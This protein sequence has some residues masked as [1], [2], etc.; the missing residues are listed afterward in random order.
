MGKKVLSLFMAFMM[1]FS[2]LPTFLTAT[3]SAE[4]ETAEYAATAENGVKNINDGV[5]VV[6]GYDSEN[7]SYSYIYYGTRNGDGIKWRVLDN[8]TLDGNEGLFLLMENPIKNVEFIS[9]CTLG[10]LDSSRNNCWSCL[11][12]MRHNWWENSTARV[13]CRAFTE[14][15]SPDT[16][17]GFTTNQRS[18]GNTLYNNN[19][20]SYDQNYSAFS[21]ME[22]EKILATTKADKNFKGDHLYYGRDLNGEKVFFL[23]ADEASDAKYGFDTDANR[24]SNTTWMTRSAAWED[25]VYSSDL[26]SQYGDGKGVNDAGIG[27]IYGDGY[28]SAVPIYSAILD[29]VLGG[30][31]KETYSFNPI[32]TWSARPAMNISY[33]SIVFASAPDAAC[34]KTF[35]LTNSYSGNE[36]KLTL[37]TG[38]SFNA[39][40]STN[41]LS[42]DGIAVTHTALNGIGNTDYNT[43]TA[44]LKNTAGETVAYGALN[45]ADASAGKSTLPLPSGLADGT[46]TLTLRAEQWNGKNMTNYAS[47]AYDAGTIYVGRNNSHNGQSFKPIVN[48]FDFAAMTADD[49]GFL[50]DNI[51]VNPN[52]IYSGHLCLNGYTVNGDMQVRNFALYDDDG[53]SGLLD[54]SLTLTDGTLTLYGGTVNTG[55]NLNKG[56]LA[57][58]GGVVG[59]NNNGCSVVAESDTTV[60]FPGNTTFNG[61]TAGVYLKNGAYVSA[62]GIVHPA[63]PYIVGLESGT[64]SFC[65]DWN[66]N[67]D[68]TQYFS[69]ANGHSVERQGTTLSLIESS[70]LVPE[71]PVCGVRCNHKDS[72]PIISDW[73]VFNASETSLAD[74][75]YIL[76]SNITLEH[77]I[78]ITGNVNVC[79]NG[80][81]VTLKDKD[82]SFVVADGGTLSI[83]DCSANQT[84]RINGENASGRSQSDSGAV[85]VNKK[86]TF[87]LYTG[88]INDLSCAVAVKGTF[89]MY[90]GTVLNSDCG[91]YNTYT[92][93][94]NMY[95]GTVSACTYGVTAKNSVD[96]HNGSLIENCRYGLFGTSIK[97]NLS[98]T[99]RGC[100]VGISAGTLNDGAVVENCKIGADGYIIMQPGSTVRNCTQYGVYAA[101]LTM[102]G[103]TVT[104]CNVGVYLNPAKKSNGKNLMTVSGAP[105]INGNTAAN[106]AVYSKVDSKN[107][108]IEN[109]QAICIGN[110]GLTEEAVIPVRV[111][112][113]DGD[114][115]SYNADGTTSP[116]YT[117]SAVYPN[118][119]YSRYFQSDVPNF[120]IVHTFETNQLAVAYCNSTKDS[121]GNPVRT[122]IMCLLQYDANGG[123]GSIDYS[124]L[125]DS[126]FDKVWYIKA[127]NTTNGGGRLIPNP[128]T[129]PSGKTFAGW[130]TKADGSGVAYA[131][132]DIFRTCITKG[133]YFLTDPVTLY[134][135]WTDA[136][137]ITVTFDA[138]GGVCETGEK[139]VKYAQSYGELPTPTRDGYAFTGWYTD[140]SN[141]NKVSERTMVSSIFN[142]TLY[143]YWTMNTYTVSFNANGG[144]GE[145]A[146]VSVTSGGYTLPECT[147]TPPAGKKFKAW[148]VSG[149]EYAAGN[150]IN[151]SANTTVT[152]VWA[153]LEKT[154]VT[155]NETVQTNEYDGIVKDF[156]IKDANVTD[157]FT[158]KYQKDGNDVVLPTDA[159]DYD[160]VIERAEDGTYKEYKKTIT[161]GLKITKK[162]ITGATVGV[163]EEMTYNGTAQTPTASVTVDGLTVTGEWSKVTNVAD[164]TTFTANGNFKG[165]IA[166]QITGMEKAYSNFAIAPNAIR[167]TYNKNAQVLITAA[168]ADGGIV[169]YSIDDQKTWSEELP[170]AINAGKYVVCFKIFGDDNHK[171]SEVQFCNA[172]VAK[173]VVSVPTVDGKIYNGTQQTAKI[174]DTEYYTVTQNGGGINTGKYNVKLA[175]KDGANYYWDGNAENVSEI[176]LDFYITKANNEWTTAPSITDRTYG[177]SASAPVY[178]AK[179]GNVKVEYKKTNEDD[180]AYTT[181]VPKNAG[182]YNA[183]FTVDAT[184]DFG[185]LLEVKEFNIAKANVIFTEPTAQ[186]DLVYSGTAQAL[187]IGGSAEGGEILYSTAENGDYSADVIKGTN[188]GSYEVWYKVAG[189]SNHNDIAPQKIDVSIAKAVVS[190][191][192]IDGK[193]YNGTQQT[194]KIA[195]T[196]YYTV[197]QNGGGINTGKYNVKLALKDGA[198]YYWDG[199]AENVSEINLD[200]YITKANNEWTTAPSITDRTYGESAS[201]PVY[202]AKFGNVKVEYKKTNEDDSAYTTDV[203]KNAGNY[204]AK[205]TVDA[206]DDFGG[207]LEVK[208]FNIAKANVTFTEPT[209]QQDLV[210]NG[211]AQALTLGGSAE[212]GETLYATAE[213]GDY[214]ADVIKGTNAGSYEV[215]YKVAGDSNHNDIASQKIN[216]SIAKA[217]QSAPVQPTAVG[218]TIKGK[219]D[220]KIIGVS[221]DMEYKAD[222]ASEYTA[223]TE[224]EILNLTAGIY[225]VRY[226]ENDN[227]LAGG[228]K[229]I[230]IVAGEMI[231]V[232]FDSDGGSDIDSETCEYN[233]TIASPKDEP[234]KDGYEF[235]GWFA[236]VELTNEWNF[237]TTL[238]ENKTLYAKWVRGTVSDNEGD[239]D[240]VAA[241]GLND[242]AKSE[243]ADI[244]LVVRVQETADSSESQTAIKNIENAPKNFEF[245]D[246]TLKKSA[247]ETITEASSVIEIKLPYDFARKRNIKIYRYHNGNAVELTQLENRNT[248]KPFTDGTCFVDTQNGYIYIYSS[249]FSIYSVAYDKMSSS[250]SVSGSSSTN[251]YTVTFETNGA[252]FVKGQTV[253]KNGTANEPN[254]PAKDGY[255]F[256]GWYLS[257]DFTDEYDFA[258]KV[259]QNITLYAKWIENKDTT[260]DGKDKPN[261]TDTHNCPS[262]EFDDLDINMWYHTDT[263][264]VLLNGLMNGVEEKT[265]APSENL[266]R[267]MLVTVLYRN[268]NN[269]AE[270][271]GMPFMDVKKGSYYE[272]AVLWAQQNGIVNGISQTEFAPDMSITREQIAAILYRYAQF[273]GIDVSGADSA[274]IQSYS[275]FNTISEYAVKPL[276]WAADTGLIKGRS[277]TTLNPKDNATRAEIAAVLH[278]FLNN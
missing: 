160:V 276:S 112:T 133:F 28:L 30:A 220:G 150:T 188:A 100:D 95:G 268:E 216:V 11:D 107:K 146:N 259:T 178:L 126:E 159:G 56:T 90:G 120:F 36:W 92:G 61:T 132:Q 79:L 3:A 9:Y 162:D 25:C 210:Y 201:A 134:A 96:L 256:G 251:Y 137:G 209:A 193:I 223:V 266:T 186:Q 63:R 71:H 91:I 81:V 76:N 103:G 6:N 143:A 212:G 257:N 154:T 60:T 166:D 53:K 244:S 242:I 149:T 19:K 121:V 94:F 218:E 208:E 101:D 135:Q 105:V 176:N 122:R 37:G 172:S 42:N 156:A 34:E 241:D 211:T 270:P 147:F 255:T 70:H 48:E 33:D 231:T 263:D 237:D 97:S 196:E 87:K 213:N 64:G 99:I 180:S 128:F 117:F 10:K 253:V 227:Y 168:E 82:V 225:K 118:R 198:N 127:R 264:Y 47:Q 7:S 109:V 267:A 32:S 124:K 67:T 254:E 230:E 66:E 98:G 165:T 222:G 89:Y 8:E 275:D 125:Q 88:N 72:H 41:I 182:N 23:S 252:G 197:T 119:D 102:N 31:I 27:A 4:E 233:Q 191:P 93:K 77:N 207:L 250:S 40:L 194:A 148:S 55:I 108:P 277:D 16:T 111:I 138:N 51:T 169:K 65:T 215:W 248:V 261:D 157:G 113:V 170:K 174:A 184:D 15:I 29:K 142:H 151:I 199:N 140:K 54:G 152:A 75:N 110:D 262:K 163:F 68:F 274:N 73:Q 228:D 234:V 20:A 44:E 57:L 39:D 272:K 192:T 38:D 1:C 243:K 46:Y 49:Y 183:K 171:D 249:K 202:L 175:L 238:T 104:G 219:A 260:D 153:N 217:T 84:G 136:D 205:F 214:S 232:T 247:G 158:V 114:F 200:F 21:D 167:L 78:E 236:D 258:E 278:R 204:N 80:Y 229:T 74:G 235:V 195:D 50:I 45:T 62:A 22:R 85:T 52:T 203:P 141:G 206:T 273:K 13:W 271:D 155:I 12:N 239:V 187:T 224:N 173:A 161:G 131:D 116:S 164:K 245:Y 221:T 226:K 5:N 58:F 179:F 181:D 35:D 26:E 14:Q 265:F 123:S 43:V 189:D 59:E 18:L 144:S 24:T 139:K 17:L 2:T 83:S 115:E 240:L 86:G 106:V 190:V 69:G 269:G 185:G 177:E 145:M 129:A 246:I 130:N